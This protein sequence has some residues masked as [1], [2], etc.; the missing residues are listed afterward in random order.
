MRIVRA[1]HP[2]LRPFV[3]AL[4]YVDETPEQRPVRANR[5]HVLPTGEMHVVFRLSGRP[6]RLFKDP[7]DSIGETYG[8]SVAG[9]A[10]AEFYVKD[11]S[12]RS[13]S[14]GAQLQPGAAQIL[15][16]AT[17]GELAGYHFPL[18]DV[19]GRR[20]LS[21]EER[22]LEERD[23]ERRVDL[24][25]SILAGRLPRIR[26]L[27]PAVAMA[28]ERFAGPAAV[29]DVVAESG[30][31]HRRFIEL[32][33]EAV[34]LAPKVYCRIQRFRRAVT[35]VAAGNRFTWADVALAAGY[36]DQAHFNREF[37]E[38]TGVTPGEYCKTVATSP[39]HVAVDSRKRK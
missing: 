39:Y 27:H 36:S 31:S 13:C 38:F 2:A 17:A 5:E 37:L 29:R 19:W 34:G 21:A 8:N 18:E 30:Y 25:E 24:L 4:W 3:K 20:T 12:T 11:V 32:F 23:P 14:A 16:G 22:L 1:P 7:L 26:A 10:R 15:F 35:Q 9:G 33:H 28:I 6:V